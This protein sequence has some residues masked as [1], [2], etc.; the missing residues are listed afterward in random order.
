MIIAADKSKV[1]AP[2]SATSGN[3]ICGIACCILSRESPIIDEM[4]I[5]T[6][7]CSEQQKFCIA[8]L[9]SAC[10]VN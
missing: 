2:S 10:L 3:E 7:L 1:V 4:A 9:K 6:I 5:S 8:V